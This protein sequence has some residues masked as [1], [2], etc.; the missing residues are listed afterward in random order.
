MLGAL[1]SSYS[2]REA[3]IFAA[4]LIPFMWLFI[5]SRAGQAFSL[6]DASHQPRLRSLS[7]KKSARDLERPTYHRVDPVCLRHIFNVLENLLA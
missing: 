3:V 1:L 2:S 7:Q 4:L 6:H 5:L